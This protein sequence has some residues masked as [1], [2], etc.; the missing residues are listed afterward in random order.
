MAPLVDFNASS[1]AH[2]AAV[3]SSVGDASEN[4]SGGGKRQ[5]RVV[6]SFQITRGNGV[7]ALIFETFPIWLSVLSP[8]SFR[9]I[10]F[11]DFSSLE[12]LKGHTSLAKLF[13]ETHEKNWTKEKFRF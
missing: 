4:D 1:G 12:Q 9:F 10:V 3:E 2:H 8:M 5:V 7:A 11:A 6:E 13:V